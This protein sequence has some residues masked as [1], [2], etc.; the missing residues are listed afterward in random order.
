MQ[1]IEHTLTVPLDHDRPDGA[2]IE[3]FAR[4]VAAHDGGDR[5]YLVFLQGGPGQEAPRPTRF[6]A[7]PRGSVARCAT[8]A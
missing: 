3:V 7:R 1:L 8:T 2:T 4:E 5:P 6:R